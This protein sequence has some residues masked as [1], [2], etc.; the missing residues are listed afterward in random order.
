V[1][2]GAVEARHKWLPSAMLRCVEVAKEF[3]VP[4]KHVGNAP[5]HCQHRPTLSDGSLRF[6]NQLIE[7]AFD[8]GQCVG[9]R[10]ELPVRRLLCQG[11]GFRIA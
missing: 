1:Y 10:D 7:Q 9:L 8:L 11:R 5:S 6:D 4:L 3:K 2:R